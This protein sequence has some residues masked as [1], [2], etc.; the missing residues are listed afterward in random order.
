[1]W[2]AV[3]KVRPHCTAVL[4]IRNDVLC[5][6]GLSCRGVAVGK[7]GSGELGGRPAL[8]FFTLRAQPRTVSTGQVA[9][10]ATL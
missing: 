10:A 6:N 8:R 2:R 4:P 5:V 9:F 7:K 3:G 1:M